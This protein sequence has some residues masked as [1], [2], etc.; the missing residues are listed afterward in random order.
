MNNNRMNLV[1]SSR[2]FIRD[3]CL[4]RGANDTIAS[5]SLFRSPCTSNEKQRLNPHLYNV[6]FIFMGTGNASQCRQ[7]LTHFFDAKR[8]DRTVNCSYKQEYC[9]FD[10][11]FQPNLPANLSFIGLSGYYYIFNNLAFRMSKPAGATTERYRIKDFS[12]KEI[13]ERLTNVVSI[14]SLNFIESIS[15]YSFTTV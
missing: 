8:N 13:A 10:H 3:P 15:S 2:L 5:T 9:T 7:R 1:A 12:E 11:T 14:N 6:S 4:A